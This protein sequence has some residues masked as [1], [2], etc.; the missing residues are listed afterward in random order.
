MQGRVHW[1]C[2]P[3]EQQATRGCTTPED[4]VQGKGQAWA[5]AAMALCSTAVLLG[6]ALLLLAHGGTQ[7]S[8][9]LCGARNPD[10]RSHCPHACPPL[11]CRFSVAPLGRMQTWSWMR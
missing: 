8:L 7:V 9:S 3:T 6:T 1:H 10:A 5:E 2:F 11:S 4:K